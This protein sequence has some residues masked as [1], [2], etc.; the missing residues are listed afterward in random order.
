MACR[1]TFIFWS[2]RILPFQFPD[3]GK[4]YQKKFLLHINEKKLVNVKFQWQEGYR[5]FSYS[6]S[7]LHD[8][9]NYIENQ[10]KHHEKKSFKDEY[11]GML[12]SH[13]IPFDER[14]LFEF[15]D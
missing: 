7:Q 14:Y 1:T 5:V 3:P 2:D 13:E 11:L 12:S 9:Y 4:G 15:Y 6:R 10:K 8:V